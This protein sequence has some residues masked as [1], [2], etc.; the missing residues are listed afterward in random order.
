MKRDQTERQ[1]KNSG[2]QANYDSPIAGLSSRLTD[3]MV[4]HEALFER[5]QEWLD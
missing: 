3:S 1:Q 4:R 2:F 5:E